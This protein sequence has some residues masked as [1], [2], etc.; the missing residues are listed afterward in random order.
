MEPCEVSSIPDAKETLRLRGVRYVSPYRLV[1]EG[2]Y[3][4]NS[5]FR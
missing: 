1:V 3:K 2:L 4:F 5:H